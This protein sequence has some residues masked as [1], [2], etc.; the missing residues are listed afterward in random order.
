MVGS[1]KFSFIYWFHVMI[2]VMYQFKSIKY[3]RA[4]V[5]PGES[6]SGKQASGRN[7]RIPFRLSLRPTRTVDGF[8]P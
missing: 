7:I 3:R 6:P 5:V 8:A 4:N 1:V 2:V